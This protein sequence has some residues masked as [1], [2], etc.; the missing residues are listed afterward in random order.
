MPVSFV[1][2]LD[3]KFDLDERSLNREVRGAFRQALHRLPKVECLDVGAGTGATARRLLQLGLA[4]PLSLTALDCDGALLEIARE[5]AA[6][7]LRDL[8]RRPAIEAGAIY[9][10]ASATELRFVACALKD[11]R[12]DR[13]CNVITAHAFLD[14][15]PLAQTLRSFAAWLQPGAYL[16]ATI[17][18]DGDTALLP[19]YDDAAF[20]A[21]LLSHY[22]DTMERRRVDGL[23]TGGARCGRRLHRL[24]PDSGFDIV[25]CG[26]SDWNITPFLGTYRGGDTVCLQALLDMIHAEADRCGRFDAGQLAR[27]RE[28][29][30]RL[31]RRRRLGLIV[32]QLDLLAQYLP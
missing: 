18:Y 23:P 2:Y 26:T 28:D 24:L 16:Y 21:G 27:W 14:V 25:A 1:E 4:T 13:P 20:E 10:S 17:N 31:L 11:Y 5:D 22:D 9:D 7:R 15:V 12:P 19:T 32:H 30:T 8:G 6:K 29:R 3:V